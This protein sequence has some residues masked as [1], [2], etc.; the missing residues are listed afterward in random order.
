MATM[1]TSVT[2][3][4]NSIVKG[5][6]SG[7]LHEYV[8]RPS[9]VNVYATSAAVNDTFININIGGTVVVADQLMSNA[10]RFPLRP[11]DLIY[12]GHALRGDRIVID[13]RAVTTQAAR[14]LVDVIPV[15]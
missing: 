8:Q 10:N 14:I 12:S 3:A 2:P 6:F 11:D 9:K 5:I 15:A 4:A 7:Q 1:T 13:V